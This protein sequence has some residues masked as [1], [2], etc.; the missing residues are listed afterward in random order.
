MFCSTVKFLELAYELL[1]VFYI[2]C[3]LKQHE[4][5]HGLHCTFYDIVSVWRT[6]L[7]PAILNPAK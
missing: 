6:N 7:K 5:S 1:V 4:I 3:K 2:Y